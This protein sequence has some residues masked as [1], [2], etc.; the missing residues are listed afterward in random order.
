MLRLLVLGPLALEVDGEPLEAP[1]SLRARLLL[2]WLALHPGTHSRAELAARLRPDVLDESA[3]QSLRQA[4][5]AL[6]GAIGDEALE[7]ARDRAG[8]ASSVWVDAVEFDR[9]AAGGDGEAALGLV[10]GELLAGLDDDWVLTERDA[11]ADRLDGLLASLGR[12]AL[13]AGDL[14]RAV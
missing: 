7:T 13:D 9:L 10:R 6:R 11:F 4:L 2:G 12:A 3:R 8:L 14:E 1:A 5:W